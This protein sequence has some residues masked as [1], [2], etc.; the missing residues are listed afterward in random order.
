MRKGHA[1][2]QHSNTHL[3]GETSATDQQR[4]SVSGN[5]EKPVAA[6]RSR[7]TGPGGPA[8]RGEAQSR[9]TARQ[10]DQ[11]RVRHHS[12]AASPVVAHVQGARKRLAAG[13][14]AA[15]ELR[16]TSTMRSQHR[17]ATSAINSAAAGKNSWDS[18]KETSG[19][20]PT[21]ASAARQSVSNIVPEVRCE[22]SEPQQEVLKRKVHEDDASTKN[23][24]EQPRKRRLLR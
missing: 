1:T 24:A 17:R 18:L 11:R 15:G 14:P 8:Q 7:A 13:A 3:K 5:V 21:P 20:A 4:R 23:H 12:H 16:Y 2:Q 22:L 10:P 19:P 9:G 6:Q